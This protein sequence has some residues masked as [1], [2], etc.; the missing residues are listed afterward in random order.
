MSEVRPEKAAHKVGAP[1]RDG[2]ARFLHQQAALVELT[3]R[4]T[5]PDALQ[6]ILEV[7]AGA[8]DVERVGVWVYSA[9]R[10]VLT[11]KALFDRGA[12][13]HTSGVE[14]AARDYPSYFEALAT[15]DVI[16]AE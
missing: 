16:A 15:E 1:P 7:V 5:R 2:K 8:L 13:V 9:D 11:C 3:R 10:Q 4:S 6:H 12:G 14:L